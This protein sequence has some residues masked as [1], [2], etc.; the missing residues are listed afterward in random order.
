MLKHEPENNNLKKNIEINTKKIKEVLDKSNE[1]SEIV[2]DIIIIIN[3]IV[4]KKTLDKEM[5]TCRNVYFTLKKLILVIL[6]VHSVH[7]K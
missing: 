1:N 3:E 6:E 7:F 5:N 2:D 4:G